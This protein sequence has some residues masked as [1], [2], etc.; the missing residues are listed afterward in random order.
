M[1]IWLV[2]CFSGA[3]GNIANWAHL[4]GFLAG[5]A[6]GLG[7]ALL[8]GGGKLIMRRHEFKRAAASHQSLAL[9]RCEVC[10]IT[11]LTHPDAEFRVSPNGMEYC[12]DHLPRNE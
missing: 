4:F 6:A 3:M 2:L 7:N 9:H 8:A 11:E 12:S 5:G 1:L 10:G